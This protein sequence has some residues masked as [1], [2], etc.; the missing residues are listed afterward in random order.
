MSEVLNYTNH[1][2]HFADCRYI[3]PVVSR[4][5][6]GVSLGINLN[7]NRSC[8]WR[9]IYCQVEG[10]VRGKPEDVDLSVLESELVYMLE[11]I[12]NGDFMERYVSLE[13][14]RFSDICVAGNG[15][16]TL[17][18]QFAAVCQLTANLRERYQIGNDTKTVLITNG[19]QVHK[20]QVQEGLA[21]LNDCN[22]EV[23]FKIDRVTPEGGAAVNQVQLSVE[24]LSNRLG[25]TAR[26]C[27][28]YIQSCWFKTAG[29]NPDISEI[30]AFV[31]F[32]ND[33]HLD[34]AGILLYSVARPPALAEGQVVSP[35]AFE[36]LQQLAKKFEL[37]GYPVRYYL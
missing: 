6:E 36:F 28:T 16:P 3:Y 34:V 26:L 7:L 33:L 17:S 27:K 1:D 10:L 19:S 2:R 23:W 8:N 12:V 30:E 37:A 9:C 22:G 32:L 13:L 25:I 31:E 18:P 14:R 24:N 35:L 15:E 29:Q 11:W 20:P 21:I 4:R 5:S